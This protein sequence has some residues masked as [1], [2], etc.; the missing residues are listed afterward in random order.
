V[1]GPS[2]ATRLIPLLLDPATV[3]PVAIYG[4]LPGGEVRAAYWPFCDYSPEYV[5]LKAGQAVGAR[6]L[7]CDVPAGVTLTAATEDGATGY[8]A[9]TTALAEAA[10][11]DSFDEFWETAFEQE[12][13]TQ[14]YVDLL[15]DFG[16]KARELT[17]RDARDDLRERHMAWVAA[18]VVAEG[19]PADEIVLVC[20]AAH[21]GRI[22]AALADGG[23]GEAPAS[24]EAA[25]TLIPYSF[26]RLSEQSGYGAGN[27]AP[28]YYQQVWE[29]QGDYDTAARVSLSRV[30]GSL[31]Q[32]G[33]SASL[34]QTIDAYSLAQVL[35]A[36]RDKPAPGV[37]EVSEAAVSCFGQG[38]AAAVEAP[39]RAI[40]VG[41]AV[42]AVTPQ[43]GRTPLQV[44]FYE[45]VR[46]LGV[47]VLDT[48]KPLLLHMVQAEEASVSIFL[49]RLKA[50]AIPF[51]AQVESGL[52]GRGRSVSAD[53]L[54]H[55]R[56][57]REKW[58][59]QWS[60]ATDAHLVEQTARGSTLAEVVGRVVREQLAR[61]SRIDEG[62]GALLQIALCDLADLFPIGM[63][64]CEA[65]G[66]DSS[67]F[68][69]LARSTYHLDGL[70]NYG[71][72][73]RLPADQLGALAGRLFTR[74]VLSLPA[75]TI[76]ADDAAAEVC[77]GLVS[78]WELVSRQSPVVA[79][80]DGF[81]AAVAS[82][83]EMEGTHGQVR[84]LALVLLELGGRL[85][86]EELT[87]RLR[88]WLS[89][90]ADAAANA[91]LVAGLFSLHRGT[92]VRNRPLIA[93]VTDFLLELELDELTPLLPVLRRSLGNLAPAERSYLA[94]TLSAVLGL[95]G[96]ESLSMLKI[97]D[98]ELER[99]R[100]ADTAVAAI[101]AGWRDRYGI[102]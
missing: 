100:E 13:A 40:M 55:L 65:L 77:A 72:A 11:Y 51:A 83:A 79:D 93:A 25:L 45:T 87:V 38:Q 35:A 31:R 1:E 9:F 102:G 20:G 67:S 17:G 74:A 34:A 14:P 73:R 26:P 36:M 95:G 80:A 78:V 6:L 56:R 70:M 27:R 57:V 86:A 7:F 2:D 42:G 8:G 41:D 81:W 48:P 96:G 82:V 88:F 32:M 44:E 62:T 101:L 37:L 76:C 91:S 21:A 99:L 60:P 53:P 59:L 29:T 98:V 49:H 58:E 50:A 69:A 52:G 71:A 24:A 61:A 43:I 23:F 85:S 84:G 97:S 92:L 5:A 54:E 89:R 12:A 15:T 30:A 28:W 16:S 46:R 47:P 75:A 3:P 33:H 22:A 19:V 63:E 4:Y 18:S 66:A 94:E 39:L 68:V 90:A 64:R 10:G